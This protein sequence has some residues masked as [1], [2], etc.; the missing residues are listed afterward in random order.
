V[1]ELARF[2]FFLGLL[3]LE[4]AIVEQAAYRRVG[5][6]RDLDE[7]KVVLSRHFERLKN[8]DNPDALSV[9]SDQQDFP[10]PDALVNSKLFFGYCG[11]LE[12]LNCLSIQG[13]NIAFAAEGSQLNTSI[14][15][16]VD[17]PFGGE[18]QVVTVA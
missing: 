2:S 8:R 16:G 11:P 12:I 1:L 15:D 18:M 7:V 13:L 3:V 9:C 17:M 5:V 4:L 6:R 14:R 10:G